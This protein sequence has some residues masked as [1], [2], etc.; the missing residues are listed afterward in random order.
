MRDALHDTVWKSD[1][2]GGLPIVA[3]WQFIQL[4]DILAQITLSPTDSDRH[5]WLPEHMGD[6]MSKSAYE[7]FHVGGTTFEPHK[8]DGNGVGS[9]QVE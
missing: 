8:R 5:C 2:M 9:G 3:V 6:F 1:I 7:L 4:C